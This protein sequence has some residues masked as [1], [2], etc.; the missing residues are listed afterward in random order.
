MDDQQRLD[1]G[2]H[3][4]HHVIRNRAPLFMA[5]V[6]PAR[7]CVIRATERAI[8]PDRGASLGNFGVATINENETWITVGECMYS[9]KCAERGSDGS[10]FAARV[11]WSKPNTLAAK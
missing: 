5:Q 9:P 2:A 4:H 8:V 11:I 10:M 7:L 6:D 1:L 3:V